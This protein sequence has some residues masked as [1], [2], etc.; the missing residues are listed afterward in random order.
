MKGLARSFVYWPGINKDI[1]DIGIKCQECAK[2]AHAPAKF[3]EH[4]WEYPKGPWER[5]HVDY[6]G[7]VA[8]KMLLVVVDAYSKWVEVKLTL[9]ATSTA[10]IAI[11]DDLLTVI[12]CKKQICFLRIPCNYCV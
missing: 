5:I 2:H 6:A 12:I 10:T 4:H 9:S 1:E 8:N 3:N 7:P 11:L